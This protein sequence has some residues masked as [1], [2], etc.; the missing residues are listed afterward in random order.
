MAFGAWDPGG[1][2]CPAGCKPCALPATALGLNYSFPA[3]YGTANVILAYAGGNVWFSGWALSTGGSLG[4]TYV[5][6]TIVCTPTC[7]YIQCWTNSSATFTGAQY[8]LY[9]S[10]PGCSGLA[11]GSVGSLALGSYTC[12]PLSIPL[13]HGAVTWTITP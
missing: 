8:T 11:G 5:A 9:E 6:G 13:T 7:T 10:T 1:C 4:T 3:F 2:N 12:S